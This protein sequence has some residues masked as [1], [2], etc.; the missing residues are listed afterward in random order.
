VIGDRDTTPEARMHHPFVDSASSLSEGAEPADRR[1]PFRSSWLLALALV[2]A[3]A[4]SS[5]ALLAL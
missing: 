3:V 2:V 1:A 5:A 4:T